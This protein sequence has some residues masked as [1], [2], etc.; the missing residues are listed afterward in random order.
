MEEEK[1]ISLFN[2]LKA[3]EYPPGFSKNQKYVLKRASKKYTICGGQLFYGTNRLVLR[4]KGEVD[5]IFAECHS[6]G[7]GH[8]GRDATIAK[9]KARYYWPNFYIDIEQRVSGHN[10][11]WACILVVLCIDKGL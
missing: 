9:V 4:G 7:G 1:Y 2:L 5:R 8:R 6:S 11:L 3:G 10:I